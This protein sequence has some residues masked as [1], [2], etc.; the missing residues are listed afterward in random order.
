MK[1][2]AIASEVRSRRSQ[3][4]ANGRVLKYVQGSPHRQSSVWLC[5]RRLRSE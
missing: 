4:R 2:G 3:Y 5:K 1:L